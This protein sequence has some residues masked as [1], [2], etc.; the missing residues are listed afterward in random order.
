M[1]ITELREEIE[2]LWITNYVKKSTNEMVKKIWNAK[3]K[4]QKNKNY[5]W[6]PNPRGRPKNN[7]K[8]NVLTCTNIRKV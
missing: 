5:N 7:N 4:I 6:N 2:I 1:Y 8:D 3:E